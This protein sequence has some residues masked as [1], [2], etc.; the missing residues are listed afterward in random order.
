MTPIVKGISSCYECYPKPTQKV[1][2]ICTI[3][4][5]PDKPV[6]CIVWAKVRIYAMFLP[7]RKYMKSFIAML[8]Q[9]CFK[10]LFGSPSESMLF[11]D[12]A[13]SGETSTYMVRQNK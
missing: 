13:S 4:S 8:V 9:E 12:E 2:P 1:Y 3:R 11:E 10:L 6:H 7:K 5:T